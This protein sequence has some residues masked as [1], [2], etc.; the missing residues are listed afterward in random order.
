MYVFLGHYYRRGEKIKT[1]TNIDYI[2]IRIRPI[3]KNRIGPSINTARKVI[4]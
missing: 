3:R 2:G 1:L 4:F